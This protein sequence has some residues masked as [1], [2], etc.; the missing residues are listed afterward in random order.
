MIV[1]ASIHQPSTSTLLLFDN[2]L[3]LSEGQ[4]AYY[5]PPGASIDYFT[6]KGYSP[7]PM[8]SPAEFMLELTNIDFVKENNIARADLI[9]KWELSQEREA[10]GHSIA[11]YNSDAFCPT[12]ALSNNLIARKNLLHQT[13]VL[14]HRMALVIHF[15]IKLTEEIVSRPPGVWCQD[16]NVSWS[17]DSDG[18]GLAPSVLHPGQHSE[19]IEC[20]L[21]WKCLHEF[22][23]LSLQNFLTKA[24]AYIPA[25]LEDRAVMMKERAN[26][27]YGPTA[28]MIAN[29]L[30]GLPFLCI[31][32]SK[33]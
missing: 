1:I 3:L 15:G 23:G 29:I 32:S 18:Y 2:V 31:S 16:C 28:F 26:G 11:A 5:G 17:R 10:L 24:V 8:L 25:F 6:S 12:C 30:I 27:L 7:P 9:S 19:R 4:T 14:F 20:T 22:H 13:I 33:C 21:L